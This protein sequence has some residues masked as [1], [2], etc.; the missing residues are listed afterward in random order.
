MRAL[1]RLARSGAAGLVATLCDLGV[2]T[3]LTELAGVSPRVAS[4]PALVAGGVVMFF[5]QKYFAFRTGG[6][7]R[8]REL[9]EFAAVQVGGLVLTGFLYDVV[10]RYV[11]SLTT[12]YVLVR[13]GVT[14]LVW[15]AYSFPLWHVV[16]RGR[17]AEMAPARD[18]PPD[19][20][21]RKSP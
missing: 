16:F 6:A 11:P 12:H 13:L 4:V 19:T 2:L 21:S 8:T 1:L 3:G 15:L 17:P 20:R 10:L 7:P 9:V 18:A 14:N 5:G